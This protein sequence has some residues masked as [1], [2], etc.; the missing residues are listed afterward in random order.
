MT[1]VVR[2]LAIL[3]LFRAGRVSFEQAGPLAELSIR[4]SGGETTG[5]V[6]DEYEPEEQ[7]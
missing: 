6:V 3:E 4:W 7:T 5:I 1:T 2:F